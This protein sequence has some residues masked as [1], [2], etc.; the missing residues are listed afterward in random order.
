MPIHGL[1][2]AAGRPCAYATSEGGAR[3]DRVRGCRVIPRRSPPSS[4]IPARLGSVLLAA[5]EKE[6]PGHLPPIR[7]SGLG[8]PYHPRAGGPRLAVSFCVKE[9]L[10]DSGR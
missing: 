4:S 2:L 1:A 9:V 6:R 7:S 3:A 5:E 10:A 8:C